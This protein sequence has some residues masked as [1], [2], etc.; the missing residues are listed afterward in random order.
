MSVLLG[1]KQ[2]DATAHNS[3]SGMDFKVRHRR[4]VKGR[5]AAGSKNGRRQGQ[6][7]LGSHV[8]FITEM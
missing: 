2:N 5:Y 8:N 3:N 7:N 4:F 1:Q 6:E